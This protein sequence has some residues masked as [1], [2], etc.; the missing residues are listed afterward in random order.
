MLTC[1]VFMLMWY[2][3]KVLVIPTSSGSFSS[4][5]RLLDC[6]ARGPRFKPQQRQKNVSATVDAHVGTWVISDG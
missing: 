4:I 2:M 5:G 6:R 1:D 3:Y